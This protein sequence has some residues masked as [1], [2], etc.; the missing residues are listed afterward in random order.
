MA[1][2][3]LSI[4]LLAAQGCFLEVSACSITSFTNSTNVSSSFYSRAL[5]FGLM[6]SQSGDQ[7]S[8][9][10]LAGVQT[11]L[12]DIN[13]RRDLLPGYSLNYTLTDTQVIL[14]AIP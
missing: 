2:I 8:T 12:D 9:G 7:Q 3:R 14:F 13:S 11:A 5:Y 4:L 10:A 6:L 1:S